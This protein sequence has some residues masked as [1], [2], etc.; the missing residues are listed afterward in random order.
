MWQAAHTVLCCTP[1]HPQHSST[2]SCCSELLKYWHR[3]GAFVQM[4]LSSFSRKCHISYSACGYVQLTLL[5]AKS[6]SERLM[7]FIVLHTHL[8]PK[9]SC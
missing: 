4:H 8:D 5:F 7:M 2:S 9:F 6:V 1:K 3:L